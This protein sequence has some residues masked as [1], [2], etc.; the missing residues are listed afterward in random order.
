MNSMKNQSDYDLNVTV[1]DGKY[2]VRAKNGEGLHAL[3]YG[4]P[5]RDLVGDGLVL[6]LAQEINELRKQIDE[7]NAVAIYAS[8]M[9]PEAAERVIAKHP[10]YLNDP[11]ARQ[12]YEAAM[13]EKSK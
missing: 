9:F 8:Q 4:E 12:A 5:W 6:A 3:R 1:A 13:K 2:T 7:W 11:V 10:E